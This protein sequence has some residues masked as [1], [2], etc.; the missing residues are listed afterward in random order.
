V[1]HRTDAIHS[2]AYPV[3]GLEHMLSIATANNAARRWEGQTRWPK[4]EA[5]NA[6]PI[7]AWI[8]ILEPLT[9]LATATK[10]QS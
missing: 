5:I 1:R 8:A 6:Q 7:E 4:D 10:D 2:P 9:P 3:V